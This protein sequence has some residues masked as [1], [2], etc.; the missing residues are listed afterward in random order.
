MGNAAISDLGLLRLVYHCMQLTCRESKISSFILNHS[1]IKTHTSAKQA[2]LE[3]CLSIGY[4][5]NTRIVVWVACKIVGFNPR[6]K[7]N[8][9]VYEQITEATNILLRLYSEISDDSPKERSKQ[10]KGPSS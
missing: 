8:F 10:S 1:Q 2:L 6:F 3:C 5:E 9:I 4:T 7:L